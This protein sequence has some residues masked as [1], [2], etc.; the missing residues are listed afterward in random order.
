MKLEK[1]Q[2]YIKKYHLSLMMQDGKEMVK[3]SKPPKS[4]KILAELK[5]AKLEILAEL[6]TQAQAKADAKAKRLA[7]EAAEREAIKSGSR[8]IKLHYRDGEYLSGYTVHGQEAET[9]AELGLAK[10]VSGWGYHVPLKAAEALGTEFTY[11][12]AEEYMRPARE[13]KDAEKAQAEAELQAKFEEAQKT[14]KPV[15]I[16]RYTVPCSDPHEECNM[17]IVL[18]YAM[19][20]GTTKRTQNHTW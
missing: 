18:E 19:P 1:V 4:Q 3:C 10:W 13:A 14:G 20:D 7:E 15:Q 8:L 17:D 16:R 9:L 2:D 12:Q 6:K 11:P 5:A